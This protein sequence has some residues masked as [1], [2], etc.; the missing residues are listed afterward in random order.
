MLKVAVC[1][2]SRMD[3]ERLE[4]IFDKLSCYPVSYDVYFSA[5][6][7][8]KCISLNRELYHLYIFDIEMPGMT[9]LELAK[10]MRESG[11]KALF[12][13][14]TGYTQYVMEAFDVFTF[15]FIPKPATIEKLES[16]IIKAMDYLDM[17]KQ[18]FVFQFCKKQFRVSCVDILYF[19]KKGRQAV[20]HT[21]PEDFKMNMTVSEILEQL[22]ERVFVQI[23][24]SYIVNMEH[25]RSIEGDEAVMD[26]GDRLLISRSHKQGLKERHMEFV[27]RMV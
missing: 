1:D 27:R 20:I 17:V 6:E 7:L 9:G 23:H 25:L 19:E 4:A 5:E 14:L 13:F 21:I 26:N 18:D 3:V 8:L 24:A 10:K 11:V 16:V 2:D 15:D 22:D 12:V